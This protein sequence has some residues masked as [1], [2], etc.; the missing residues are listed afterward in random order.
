MV[1]K[2]ANRMVSKLAESSLVVSFFCT[3]SPLKSTTRATALSGNRTVGTNQIN[4]VRVF[5]LLLFLCLRSGE[6]CEWKID[7][8]DLM[9]GIN[10]ML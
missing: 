4:M 2:L 1:G 6:I 7:P 9:I 10:Q 3:F 8:N 5:T